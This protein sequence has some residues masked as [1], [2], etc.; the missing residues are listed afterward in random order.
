MTSDFTTATFR[1]AEGRCID[2]LLLLRQQNGVAALE[3][4]RAAI[5]AVEDERQALP[6]SPHER[7][8]WKPWQATE[9]LRWFRPLRGS[10]N[11]IVLQQKWQRV[12]IRQPETEPP[13]FETEHEW[14]EVPVELAD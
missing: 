4:L 1:Y 7:I 6:G 12:G 2:A 3:S 8:A 5:E 9:T 11:E 10:D 13:I 14:R